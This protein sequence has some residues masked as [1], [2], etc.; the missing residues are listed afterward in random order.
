MSGMNDD[1]VDPAKI[2]PLRREVVDERRRRPAVGE[3]PADFLFEDFRLRQLAAFGKIEQPLVGDAAPQEEREPR[4]DLEVAHPIGRRPAGSRPCRAAGSRCTRSRK[5]GSTSMRSSANWMPASKLPPSRPAVGE[6]REQRL[7]VG[8]RDRPPV[9]EPRD[10]RQNPGRTGA[11]FGD[12]LG[13]ADEQRAA[14]RRVLRRARRLEGTADLDRADAGVV[15]VE[16]IVR[17]HA[18][19]LHAAAAGLRAPRARGRTTRRPCAVPPESAREARDPCRRRPACTLP[20]R[21]RRRIR[22]RH[23]RHSWPPPAGLWRRRRR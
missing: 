19:A 3:H 6:E 4:R 22:A 20:T 14:A 21:D 5:S 18:P 17:Q 12:G 2:Q 23:H 16:L 8:S 9:G 11:L 1:L 13:L 10:A 15:H 7:E